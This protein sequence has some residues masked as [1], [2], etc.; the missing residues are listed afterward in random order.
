MTNSKNR[1]EPDVYD[2]CRYVR[3]YHQKNG[4]APSVGMLLGATREYVDL[5][6]K[7][8]I[9]EVLPLHEKG[10]PVVVVLTE[11]GF[12]MATAQRR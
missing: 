6:V 4:Y 2:V 12:R 7:N 3:H 8:G 9:I 10:P 5:L 1:D 11:K